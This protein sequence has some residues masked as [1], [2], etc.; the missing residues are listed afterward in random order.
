MDDQGTRCPACGNL[1]A[2]PA[3]GRRPVWCSTACRQRAHKARAAADRYAAD[4]AW[5]RGQAAE[6][7]STS[8]A[9]PFGAL[10]AAAGL[11]I[12]AA[13]LPWEGTDL[14]TVTA[15]A[16]LWDALAAALPAGMA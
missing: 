11:V 16:G 2:V 8:G 7:D 10:I 15:M 4:A 3:T 14:D 12:D 9:G 5:A 13:L 6:L 1:L